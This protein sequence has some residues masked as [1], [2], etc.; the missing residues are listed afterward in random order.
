MTKILRFPCDLARIKTMRNTLREFLKLSR[1]SPRS[2]ASTDFVS[3]PRKERNRQ[4]LSV[5]FPIFYLL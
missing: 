4:Q 3:L 1:Q 5:P 2:R